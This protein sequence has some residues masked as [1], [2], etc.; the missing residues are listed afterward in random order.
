MTEW[1][2]RVLDRGGQ[3]VTLTQGGT[4]REIR[5]FLQPVTEKH[6]PPG[7]VTAIGTMDRRLWLYLGREAVSPGDRVAWGGRAFTVKNSAP[8]YVGETLSHWWA[9]LEKETAT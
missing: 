8:F 9:A 5:A 3:S 6:Q 4:V 7:M 2:Q 1:F